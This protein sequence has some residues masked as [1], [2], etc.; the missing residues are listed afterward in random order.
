MQADWIAIGTVTNT[1]QISSV[2]YGTYNNPAGT[3]VLASPM[4]WSN[5]APVWLYKKSDG[6]VVLVGAA[7]DYGASEYGTTVSVAPPTNLR[8]VVN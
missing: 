8:L 7:P 4:T 2:T 3:I 6:A 5:G 1:V